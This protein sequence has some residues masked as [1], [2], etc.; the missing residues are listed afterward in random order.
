MEIGQKVKV[1]RLRDRVSPAVVNKLGKVGTIKGYKMTDGSGV[2]VVVQF[3][4]NS[5]TWFFEDELK[6]AQ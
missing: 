3:D 5:T 6:P 4:D 2:G 1:Y